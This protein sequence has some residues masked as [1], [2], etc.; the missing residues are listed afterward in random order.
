MSYIGVM[1]DVIFAVYWHEGSI[2]RRVFD[3]GGAKWGRGAAVVSDAQ[4]YFSATFCGGHVVL[5]HRGLDGE[6][7][8]TAFD[9]AGNVMADVPLLPIYFNTAARANVP[10]FVA[11]DHYLLFYEAAGRLPRRRFGGTN[12]YVYREVFKDKISDEKVFYEGQNVGL[13]AFLADPGGIHGVFWEVGL[14][15]RHIVYKFR[16]Q[17]DFEISAAHGAQVINNM[18]LHIV[19]NKLKILYMAEDG[20]YEVRQDESGF[21]AVSLVKQ[22]FGPAEQARFLGGG[23][24]F[25]ASSVFVDKSKPWEILAGMEDIAKLVKKPAS[26]KIENAEK[27]RQEDYD[28][29]FNN[30]EDEMKKFLKF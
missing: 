24:A 23:T 1:E 3:A 12:K 15:G 28:D 21:S 2:W 13:A 4:R 9:A 16:G 30:M 22:P 19:D 26:K 8:Q 5:Q 11:K 10:V 7:M 17:V 18:A 6:D 14:F 27:G 29:F 25:M 20:L